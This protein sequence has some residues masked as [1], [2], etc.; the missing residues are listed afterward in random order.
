VDPGEAIEERGLAGPV[1]P[2]QPDDLPL[3]DVDVDVL[4]RLKAA[5]ADRDVVGFQNLGHEVVSLSLSLRRRN[6]NR[7]DLRGVGSSFSAASSVSPP[8]TATASSPVS[9]G[10]GSLT[11]DGSA[12]G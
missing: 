5:E 1:R 7:L 10:S 2:D 3:A 6:P 4:E 8:G 11:G 12:S 9:A